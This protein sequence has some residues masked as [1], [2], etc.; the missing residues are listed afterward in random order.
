MKTH[1]HKTVAAKETAQLNKFSSW[2][3]NRVHLFSLNLDMV[4]S[5]VKSVITILYRDFGRQ[6]NRQCVLLTLNKNK[7]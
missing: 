3:V 6:R 1:A 2:R 5:F 4:L 7:C